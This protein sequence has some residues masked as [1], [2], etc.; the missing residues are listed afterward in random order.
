MKNIYII[1]FMGSGKS[2]VGQ[3][4][5][6]RWNYHFTDT[7]TIIEKK[8]NK[9][10]PAIFS[11]EGEGKFR[12]YESDA[13]R[14]VPNENCVISTGGGIVVNKKNIESMAQTGLIVFLDTSF[15]VIDA[16]L[17]SDVSRPLWNQN[18]TKQKQLY[19]VRETIYRSCA[20]LT[21]NTDYKTMDEVASEIL[22]SIQ[23]IE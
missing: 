22:G 11:Q 5:S 23:S 18:R 12:T 20:Q 9:T 2:S 7:D 4:I 16:R 19:K 10:I 8:Y 21:V 14:S 1:G 17:R 6:E 13:L 3:K 15:N